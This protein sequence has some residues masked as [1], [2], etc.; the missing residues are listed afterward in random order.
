VEKIKNE[1]VL[2]RLNWR[3]ATKNF[4]PSKKISSSDWSTLEDA[5]SLAPSSYGLQPYRFYIAQTPE[6]RKKLAAA[7]YG[8]P[9]IESCSHL[10][11]VT[12]LKSMNEEY[13]TNYIRRICKV[14]NVPESSL[15]GFKQSMLSTV[16]YGPRSE[17]TIQSAWMAKQGYIPM[18]FFMTTAALLNID[19]CPMEGIDS[20]K[21][22]E[23][24]S[25]GDSQYS[26]VAV[27]ASGYRAEDDEYQHAKKVRFDKKEL[28]KFL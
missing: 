15:E 5:L 24:L 11:V 25:L 19:V 21:F 28:I 4:D 16:I 3:Y 7:A 9:Q 12:R 18:G 13:V 27:L 17:P 2:S 20:Q 8:Q 1:N 22:D 10:V 14:R 23:I 26:S 6:L